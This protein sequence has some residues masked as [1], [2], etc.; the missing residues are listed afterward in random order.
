MRLEQLLGDP[1]NRENLLSFHSAMVWDELEQFPDLAI[2]R[3][4][5]LGLHHVY[6]PKSLGGRF[7]HCESFIALGRVLARRNMSVVVSYSTMLWAML[8]WVGGDPNQQQTIARAILRNGEFPCLAYSEELHGADLLANETTARVEEKGRYRVCGEKW[9]VNRATRSQW[10]VLLARTDPT[11]HV[12]NQSLFFFEKARLEVGEY[13]HL[14]GAKTHGLRGCDISGIGFRD[15]LLPRDAMIGCE[16]DGM[17]L[18]LKGFQITRTFCTALSLGVGDSALRLAADFASR[19]RLYGRTVAEL[20]HARD[21]LANA[22]LSLLIGEC[23]AVAAARGL[24]LFPEQFS[25]WSSIAK[26]Q[27]TRLTDHAMHQLAG[28]LGARSYLREHHAE[29][30]FQKFLRDGA[31]VAVFDGSSIVCLDRLATV[32]PRL[33]RSRHDEPDE[34]AMAALFDLRR[35]LPSLAFDRLILLGCGRDAILQGLPLLA[36]KLKN[37][38]PDRNCDATMLEILSHETRRLEEAVAELRAAVRSDSSARNSRNSAARF[39]LAERYC[40][41]HTAICC[42]GFWLFNRDHF[43]DFTAQGQWLAAALARQGEELFRSGSMNLGL[44]DSLCQQLF[45]QTDQFQMYSLMPW[46]IADRGQREEGADRRLFPALPGD[47]Y[48]TLQT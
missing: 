34:Q 44:A 22:Y 27:V 3:L 45:E 24:H 12:R 30:M 2:A 41:L 7:E 38:P 10:V 8:A 40:A 36:R 13:F 1:G 29:G 37:L 20:P 5:S 47:H 15:C 35:P 18:A 33:C 48:S 28:I 6:V 14:P 19:R 25:A 4:H 46:P 9:P 31:I 42:L 43:D 26:V 17:E 23:A 32:L 39:G 21:T 16:G 11:S